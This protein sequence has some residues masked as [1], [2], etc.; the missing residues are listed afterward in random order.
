MNDQHAERTALEAH[1]EDEA[2]ATTIGTVSA[3]G[4]GHVGDHVAE[5][6]GG[7][8]DRRQQQPVEVPVLHVEHERR[9]PGHAGDA[10]QDRRR[11]LER[12]VVEARGCCSV[13]CSSVAMFTMKKNSAM[14]TGGMTASRSRGTARS[15]RPAMDGQVVDEARRA[16]PGAS[17]R[18][19]DRSAMVVVSGSRSWSS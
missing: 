7:A 17:S 8:P 4:H 11:H 12:G 3:G 2:R 1:A 13:S 16:G 6:D 14:N 18:G 5:Q 10:E 9:R 15:A 19:A